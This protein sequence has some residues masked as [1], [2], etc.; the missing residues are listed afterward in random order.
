MIS[1][2]RTHGNSGLTAIQKPSAH[3]L[4][5]KYLGIAA[6]AI[7]LVWGLAI[8]IVEYYKIGGQI[9]DRAQRTAML[10]NVQVE[11]LLDKPG[12]LDP[13]EFQLAL[14]RMVSQVRERE[15]G[16]FAAI[17]IN[18]ID[19]LEL[20]SM[21][22]RQYAHAEAVEK[23]M[24]ASRQRALLPGNFQSPIQINPC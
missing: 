15:I 13:G 18:D 17:V 22:E 5:A 14:E 12:L 16:R 11:H 21:S 19:S 10:L 23:F 8:F 9:V 3:R 24:N 7:S 20:A 2:Y 1:Q 6:L 4:L